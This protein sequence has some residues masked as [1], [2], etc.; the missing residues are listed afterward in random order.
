M[1]IIMKTRYFIWDSAPLRTTCNYAIEYRNDSTACSYVEIV[2]GIFLSP[3]F[4]FL[5]NIILAC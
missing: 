3:S 5:K 4:Q 1:T 2:L